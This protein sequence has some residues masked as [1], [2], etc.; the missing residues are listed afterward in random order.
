MKIN[1][2]KFSIS[3]LCVILFLAMIFLSC[4]F[5]VLKFSPT[6]QAQT[7]DLGGYIVSGNVKS[8]DVN[9]PDAV[10]IL[11]GTANTVTTQ[12]D[13]GG[14][15][16]FNDVQPGSYT[17]TAAKDGH[18]FTPANR[19]LPNLNSDQTANFT[20]MPQCVP[21]SANLA[22]WYKGEG[23]AS[24]SST[25]DNHGFL[26]FGA[27][28][29]PGKVDQAFSFD[30]VDDYFTLNYPYVN[31]FGTGDFTVEF[32]VKFDD[33]ASGSNGL[34]AKDY[35]ASGSNG[36]LFNI[37]DAAGGVGFQTR[38]SGAGSHNNARYATSNFQT[39]RWYHLAGIRR[40]GNLEFYV[41]GVLRATTTEAVPTNVSN[42]SSFVRIGSSSYESPQY[43]AGLI[44]EVR[45]FH[46]ALSATEIQNSYESGKVGVCTS[47]YVFTTH[48]SGKIAF[49]TSR[50]VGNTQIFTMNAD[51][52]N[53]VNISNYR[54]TGDVESSWS[55]DGSKIVYTTGRGTGND[56]IFVMN[57]DGSNQTR[58]T[59]DAGRDAL[60]S[61]SPDG[62][63]IIFYSNRTGGGDI[64]LMNSDAT[65]Q[66]RLTSDP[67]IEYAP[68]FSPD[69]SKIVFQTNRD[70]NYEIYSMN[71]DGSSPVRLTNNTTNDYMPVFSPD[72]SKIVY[73]NGSFQVS[74]MNADGSNPVGLTSGWL[75]S[76]SPDGTKII[77]AATPPG[78]SQDDIYIMN[79]D[80]S[81]QTN[82]TNISGSDNFPSWQAPNS[83]V[84]VSPASDLNLT[85]NNVTQA[86]N[87]IADLLA[88]NQMPALPNGY[89]LYSTAPVYDIRTTAR[90]GNITVALNVSNVAN[91]TLCGELRL[92]HFEVNEWSI[93]NNAAPVYNAGTLQCTLRQTVTSVSPFA[94]AHVAPT[95]ANV[96]VEGRV[97]TQNGRGISNITVT[98]IDSTGRT[99]TARTSAFGFYRFDGVSIGA[100]VISVS[101]KRFTFANPA[102]MINVIDNL[103][104]VDF[105]AI[106]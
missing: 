82:L 70:G 74:V 43:F 76:W 60:P 18:V 56:D 37:D 51:G 4:G 53:P 73:Y 91:S 11:R 69:G 79:P 39:A 19:S 95:A 8:G 3:K 93:A 49:S 35:T 54:W 88:P 21:P 26:V 98:L 86:G 46:A 64:Y 6:A 24:D 1:T 41:D 57:A 30:G 94:V 10:I 15:Y 55:P 2:G 104:G 61:W 28:F 102:Q 90:S 50:T 89:D 13:A 106:E 47:N 103:S 75:A 44:D 32:W 105:T 84:S 17:L 7:K 81:G 77:Y 38:N 66:T 85:F 16:S 27:G 34:V 48:R 12:T 100:A 65:N 45:A 36:W 33:L 40:G 78:G 5:Y 68:K 67:N 83:S 71:A 62:K 22:A 72:G 58:L 20:G 63:K 42:N 23:N 92:M 59:T 96:S 97:S 101:A 99:H 87:T 29:A 9:L 25:H 14:N 80:G 52:S 31:D